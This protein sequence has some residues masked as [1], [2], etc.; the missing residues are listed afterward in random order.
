MNLDRIKGILWDMDGVIA[1]TAE[2]HYRTWVEVL[3]RYQI[4]YTPEQFHRYFG[5]NNQGV[6]DTL[7]GKPVDPDFVKRIAGEK[8]RQFREQVDGSLKPYPGVE[9]CLKKFQSCGYRQVVASSAPSENIELLI[10]RLGLREYFDALVSG[11]KMHGKPAPDVFLTAARDINLPPETCVVIED[12]LVGVAA[13]RA[14]GMRCIAVTN[15][16]K[17]PDLSAAD[18]I[19]DS[20]EEVARSEF[21]NL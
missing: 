17:A 6:M 11:L 19:V 21:L 18:W 14:A 4:E 7:M 5:M 2:L 20:L 10:N 8:E 9:S 13:A 16:N 3:S 15:T 12:S 1:D